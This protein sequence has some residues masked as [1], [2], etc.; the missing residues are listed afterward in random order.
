MSE[1][2]KELRKKMIGARDALAYEQRDNDSGTICDILFVHPA[3]LGAKKLLIFASFGSEPD[4]DT[5]AKRALDMGKE[6]YY[7]RVE[8]S[9]ISFYAVKDIS[10]LKSGYK[11]IREPGPGLP[12]DEDE[13]ASVILVPGTAFDRKGRRMGYGGGFYDRFLKKYPKLYRIGICFS[14]QITDDLPAEEHDEKVNEVICGL[15]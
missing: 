7:P 11:G 10:E 13:E 1:E 4:T 14:I 3:V 5:I 12:W 8:D 6:I 2:K 9:E 15:I